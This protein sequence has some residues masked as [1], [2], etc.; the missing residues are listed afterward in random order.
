MKK[1][2]IF[3]IIGVIFFL[4]LACGKSNETAQVEKN[5]NVQIAAGR[6]SAVKIVETA[7]NPGSSRDKNGWYHDWDEGMAAAKK[8]EKPVLV[9]FYT[10]WCKWCEVMDEKTFSAPEI[11]KIFASD[12]I[13]IKINAEENRKSGTFKDENLT[14][15]KL[16]MTLG[17]RA[18]PSYLFIDK[19]GEIVNIVTGFK[20]KKQFSAI[21]DY[22]KNEIYKKDEKFQK[23]YIESR[24]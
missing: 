23:E 21:L 11:M 18:F 14:Y 22:F 13:T 12:W 10:D 9:D 7:T 6:N 2:R 20:E 17:V 3:L 19:E 1:V 15:S 8:A 16:A 24:S 5:H 4:F